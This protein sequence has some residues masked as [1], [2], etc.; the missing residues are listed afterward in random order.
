MN[1][2][3]QKAVLKQIGVSKKEF[4]NNISDYRDASA[5]ISGFIYYSDT[6][7]FTMDNQT[8]IIELLEDMADE[9]GQ[10]V[11]EMVA[12]FGV[13]GGEMDY[14]DK[15]DLY[16][17]LSGSKDVKQGAV[18]NVLAWLCVEQLAYLL[19]E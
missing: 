7:K 2:K 17:F 16:S 12:G 18:T 11:G 5:G 3:L 19:D 13:F 9:F 6:H 8:E 1:A 4:I 14:Q 15:K 10:E